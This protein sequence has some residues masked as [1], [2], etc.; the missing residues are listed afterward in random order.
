MTLVRLLCI[1]SVELLPLNVVDTAY[2]RGIY[3]KF[4]NKVLCGRAFGFKNHG[5][6]NFHVQ[7]N[8]SGTQASV[9]KHR[10]SWYRA[11]SFKEVPKF[12]PRHVS[13][14]SILV[15]TISSST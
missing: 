11:V 10:P 12:S 2:F 14:P 8:S 5:P 1:G 15:N 13:T 6:L 9:N 7:I 3:G 4:N